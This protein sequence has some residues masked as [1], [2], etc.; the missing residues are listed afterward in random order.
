MPT[1]YIPFAGEK[2][3]QANCLLFAIS[4]I[5]NCYLTTLVWQ[6]QAPGIYV[7]PR[8]W[9]NLLHNVPISIFLYILQENFHAFRTG[10]CLVPRASLCSN[11]CV[12]MLDL[13]KITKICNLFG[14]SPKA[15]KI[16]WIL[17]WQISRQN[18]E[19][20]HFCKSGL[21]AVFSTNLKVAFL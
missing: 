20:I 16:S 9:L 17:Y 5:Y 19:F 11:Y 4:F 3:A 8:V 21:K 6:L 2:S 12:S 7:A 1:G 18:R 15:W 13:M 14:L 10:Y